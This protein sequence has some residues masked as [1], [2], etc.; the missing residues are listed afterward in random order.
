MSSIGLQACRDAD[1]VISARSQT[2]QQATPGL[3]N[4][5][6]ALF[7][8]GM[9]QGTDVSGVCCVQAG[10][11]EVSTADY[12]FIASMGVYVFK[13]DVLLELLVE[14]S[15]A[16]EW[17]SL[18]GMFYYQSHTIQAYPYNELFGG[19]M[20]KTVEEVIEKMD[21]VYQRKEVGFTSPLA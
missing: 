4:V 15:M 5:L 21:E 7:R 9:W 16:C 1:L 3:S 19:S 20:G 13:R 10:W 14:N 18:A 6:W 17:M 8:G 2:R 11:D 12:P